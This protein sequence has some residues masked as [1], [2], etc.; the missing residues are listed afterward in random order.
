MQSHR[1]VCVAR[2]IALRGAWCFV[3]KSLM[4]ILVK[5]RN[6]TTYVLTIFGA[7]DAV[8]G[9][10]LRAPWRTRRRADGTGRIQW[11]FLLPERLPRAAARGRQPRARTPGTST[12]CALRC[13][14]RG[15]S[16]PWE[17][18]PGAAAGSCVYLG[19]QV[20]SDQWWG[21]GDHFARLL[22]LPVA[23]VVRKGQG[24][25]CGHTRGCDVCQMNTPVLSDR[26]NTCG[27]QT[28]AG[29]SRNNPAGQGAPASLPRLRPSE[30]GPTRTLSTQCVQ[31]RPTTQSA[32]DRFYSQVL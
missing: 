3:K 24:R 8:Y 4:L 27:G 14:A 2:K 18:W 16:G 17:P 19:G 32:W 29:L 26:T 28:R 1:L 11:S 30:P 15:R 22:T 13:D 9:P 6:S 21:G 10:P 20:P 5:N 23:A 7:N 31:V 25:G 12:F